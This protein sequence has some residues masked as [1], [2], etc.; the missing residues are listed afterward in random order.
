MA[1]KTITARNT[2][3]SGVVAG[4]TFA[5]GTATVDDSTHKGKAAIE[6]AKRHGWAVSGGTASAVDLDPADG[7]DIERWSEAELEAYLTGHGVQFP[8]GASVADLKAAVRD[9][10]EV[11]AQGGS[12]GQNSAGHTSGTIPPEGAPPVSNPDKP[13]DADKAAAWKTPMVGNVLNDVAPTISVQ[14][15]GTSKVEPATATYTVTATGTPAPTYQW[16]RQAK[17]SGSYVDI[18]G[19]DEASY[20]TPELTVADNHNDRYRVVVTNSD[21]SV[22]STSYQQAVTAS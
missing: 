20:T 7:E 22:T 5:D 1:S 11:K 9:A 12:A 4:A 14:P 15:T 17:G 21:G 10:F 6:F 19:A 3:L 8:S 16:Q 18:E 2:T 13:D